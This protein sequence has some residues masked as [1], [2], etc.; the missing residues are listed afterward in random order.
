MDEKS[1]VLIRFFSSLFFFPTLWFFSF[2]FFFFLLLA[3]FSLS[4]CEGK[5]KQ[6]NNLFDEMG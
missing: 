2:S 6:G 5:K 1:V 3:D 4:G